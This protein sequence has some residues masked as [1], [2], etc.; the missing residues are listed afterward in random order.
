M[1][2][3]DDGLMQDL[4]QPQELV[5]H[6]PA[7]QRIQRAERFVEEPQLRLHRQAAG[8]ADA[9]LLAAGKLAGE[10]G[11]A[12]FQ[13]HQF[14]HFRRALQ[15]LLG[16]QALHL[17][18]EG[19]V[20]DDVQ[21]GHEAEILEH[22]AHLAAADLRQF[23]ARGAQ[24]ILAVEHDLAGGR[25]HQARQ[26]AHHRG[27]ARARQAHDDEDLAGMDIERDVGGRGDMP[28]VA[29]GLQ[30]RGRIGHLAV[31]LGEKCR[32]A[33]AIDLPDIAAGDLDRAVFRN[34]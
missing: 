2:D 32:G 8:D 5:L 29:G 33:F 22:H 11:F 10:I 30:R 15:P 27:F 14:D 23:L 4:L 25:L 18:R 26:A 21:M 24:Q 19:D 1:S 9:L 17:Q 13:A 7:D 6:L 20:V 28:A 16:R 3:E 31:A 34:S 12:A